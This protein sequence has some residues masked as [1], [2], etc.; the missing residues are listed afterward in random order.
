MAE[1]F[2][3]EVFKENFYCIMVFFQKYSSRDILPENILM[4]DLTRIFERLGDV[5]DQNLEIFS[6]LDLTRKNFI[7][8]FRPEGFDQK[9]I[10]LA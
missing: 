3:P 2:R 4:M 9:R 7:E 1:N 6:K 5:F 10:F 8:Y